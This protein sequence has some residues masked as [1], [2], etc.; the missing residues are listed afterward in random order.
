MAMTHIWCKLYDLLCTSRARNFFTSVRSSRVCYRS[1]VCSHSSLHPPRSRRC[2]L[3]ER[4]QSSW[5]NR[6]LFISGG[7]V[8]CRRCR[9]GLGQLGSMSEPLFAPF[10][11]LGLITD[12]VPFCVSRRGK[13]TFATL[14]VGSSWQV[15]NCAKLT[16]SLVGPQ[17]STS[18]SGATRSLQLVVE[19]PWPTIARQL[20]CASLHVARAIMR[21]GSASRQP[22]R[23]RVWC[24]CLG[25]SRCWHAKAISRLRLSVL[26]CTF[27]AASTKWHNGKQKATLLLISFSWATTW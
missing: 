3:C 19:A 15:Y 1:G 20:I 24:S 18:Q 23:G 12:S 2:R 22:D 11:A 4:V 26:R 6:C 13:E 17:V 16:L 9:L 27:A 21:I 8:D 14:S 7:D 5:C 25:T 10:R